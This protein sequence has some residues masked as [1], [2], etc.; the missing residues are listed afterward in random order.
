MS[1]EIVILEK[2][3]IMQNGDG[4]HTDTYEEG[5]HGSFNYQ[6]GPDNEE[7]YRRIEAGESLL[8]WEDREVGRYVA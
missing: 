5:E 6:E 2:Y 7:Y 8:K 3:A 1:T 4:L